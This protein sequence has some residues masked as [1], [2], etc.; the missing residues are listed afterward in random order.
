MPSRK[1]ERKQ[2]RKQATSNWRPSPEREAREREHFER[3][4]DRESLTWRF[5]VIDASDQLLKKL[6]TF[7]ERA[8]G[9]PELSQ[10]AMSL[11]TLISPGPDE[12][13]PMFLTGHWR[14]LI[15]DACQDEAMREEANVIL[16]ELAAF[17]GKVPNRRSPTLS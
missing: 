17:N 3:T 15:L 9:F 1:S 13:W 5:E 16:R 7:C 14:E 2:L 11:Q 8:G 4:L 6:R 10:M 12:E